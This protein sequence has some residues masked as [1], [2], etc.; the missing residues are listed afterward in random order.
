MHLLFRI[1]YPLLISVIVGF[2]NIVP[3]FGPLI[4][5]IPSALILLLINPLSALWFQIGRAHV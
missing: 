2:T 4:G 5:A 1:E 3:F